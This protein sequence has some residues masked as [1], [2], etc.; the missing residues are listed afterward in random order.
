MKSD[1]FTP[2]WIACVVIG[3]VLI[4]W[5]MAI[6]FRK[7]S[8]WRIAKNSKKYFQLNKEICGK[9]KKKG[10]AI[11]ESYAQYR[12]SIKYFNLNKVIRCSNSVVSNSSQNP[13]K[14]ILKYSNI[15]D[16]VEDM[17]RLEFI[18]KFLTDHASFTKEMDKTSNKIKRKL[19]L[20]YRI[21]A[22]KRKLPYL[23]CE[24]NYEL[25]N[26]KEPFLYFLY[27]SPRGRSRNENKI[28]ID[29]NIIKA[30]VYEVSKTVSKKG[31]SKHQR[32]IM[33]NDLREA[34][35]KRDNYTC[36]KCGN[37]VYDEPNLLLEVDHI[38]PISKGGKTEA[39]NLQT[40]CWRCNRS[41]SNKTN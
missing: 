11:L 35:K 37:S 18:S 6:C 22:D 2:I 10:K 24:L 13:I 20:F 34:I 23:V 8:D 32:S 40:L 29:I 9:T 33:T 25:T 19:P 15:N 14:Y 5:I 16:S 26:I 38:I 39:S 4:I 27:I 41:K 28:T 21:F 1:A 12:D 3:I 17:E 31:H 7:F 36:C 30:L